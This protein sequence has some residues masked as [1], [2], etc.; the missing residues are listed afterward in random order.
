VLNAANEVAVGAFL[1]RGL[2]FTAIA[3]IVEMTMDA[4]TPEEVTT[5][6]VVRRADLWAR[7]YARHAAQGLELIG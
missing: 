7:E 4:H 3:R 2:G 5:L 1:E 6:Q